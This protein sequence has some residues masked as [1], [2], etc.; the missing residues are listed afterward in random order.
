[1]AEK[2]RHAQ[3]SHKGIVIFIVILLILVMIGGS[4]Y[5]FRDKIVDVYNDVVGNTTT[6]PVTTVPTT[7]VVTT[8]TV[9]V[10]TTAPADPDY[11]KATE[12][13]TKMGQ[14]EK[15]C[16]L[17]VVTPEELTNVDVATVAGP[18]TKK[19]LAKYPVGGI[20]YFKQNRADDEAFDDMLKKTKSYAKTP[21][22]IMEN[23]E[24]KIFAYPDDLVVSEKLCD[25]KT[26]NGSEAV[27]AFNDG[28]QI[29]MMPKNLE[30]AVKKFAD[31]VKDGTIDSSAVDEA[32]AKVLQVKIKA[33]LIK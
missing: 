15:I 25:G 17:F 32:V 26:T 31:A 23:G 3:K 28:C 8:T 7:E 22:F 13:V 6:T 29:L 30:K 21:L 27:E 9:P 12:L 11:E 33:G 18:T 14:N 1:M 19:Q 10:T 16:Q 2:G 4:A 20:V 5:V 24:K